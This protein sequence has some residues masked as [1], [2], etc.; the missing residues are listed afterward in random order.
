MYLEN[1]RKT[2]EESRATKDF[3]S[4]GVYLRID[5]LSFDY[6]TGENRNE[7]YNKFNEN[8]KAGDVVALVGPS[9]VGKSTLLNLITKLD[10]PKSGTIYFDG[11]ALSEMSFKD[12]QHKVSYVTQENFLFRGTLEEN[13]VYGNHGFDCSEENLKNALKLTNAFNFTSKKG[14]LAMQI[15]TKGN[16]LSGGEKQRIIMARALVKHPRLLLLDE[17]TAGVDSASE[18]IIID[19]LARS[20]EGMTIIIITHK[21][22]NFIPIITKFI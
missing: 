13:L 7:M 1:V 18:R 21:L 8:I 6:I 11:V 16:N 5:N 22:E 10:E 2:E 15:E 3:K 20:R 14:G 9:G 19:N 4:M 12:I 17:A